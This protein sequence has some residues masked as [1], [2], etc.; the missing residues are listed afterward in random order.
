VFD[1]DGVVSFKGA[2]S[3]GIEQMFEEEYEYV[4]MLILENT[5]NIPKQAFSF[6]NLE[7]ISVTNS[8]LDSV[9]DL[10]KLTKLRHLRLRKCGLVDFP[11]NLPKSLETLILDWNCF[12]VVP[13]LDLPALTE[14][15]LTDCQVEQLPHLNKMSL[16][17]LSLSKN[18]G[19]DISKLKLPHTLKQLFLTDMGAT[20]FPKYIL[21]MKFIE[22]LSLNGNHFDNIADLSGLEKLQ[23]L[24]LGDMEHLTDNGQNNKNNN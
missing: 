15:R 14:L 10:T 20:Q 2:D 7:S 17:V 23:H 18:H 8:T 6:T 22:T 21:S 5:N 16:E 12:K 13:K 3:P 19:L 24:F 4:R 1:P 9:P 11:G